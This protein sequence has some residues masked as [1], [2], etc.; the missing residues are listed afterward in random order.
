MRIASLSRGVVAFYENMADFMD[1]FLVFRVT[2]R[3]LQKP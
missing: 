2:N 1:G 3:T